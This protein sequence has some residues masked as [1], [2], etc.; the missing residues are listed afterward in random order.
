MTGY[1]SGFSYVDTKKITP[2]IWSPLRTVGSYDLTNPNHLTNF[3]VGA[4][5]H[6]FPH[7]LSCA[8]QDIGRTNG[9]VPNGEEPE[10]WWT[11]QR[12]IAKL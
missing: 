8:L 11:V 7:T 9:E 4:K 12:G 10:R 2:I 3:I 6:M 5:Y 1:L